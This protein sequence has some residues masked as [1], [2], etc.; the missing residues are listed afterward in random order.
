MVLGVPEVRASTSSEPIDSGRGQA[1]ESRWSQVKDSGEGP[2][3][4]KVR[5]TDAISK[6][7]VKIGDPICIL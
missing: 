3:E 4:K 2:F 6:V 7:N 5:A 1:A